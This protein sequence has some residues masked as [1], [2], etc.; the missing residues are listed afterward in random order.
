MGNR[1]LKYLSAAA[2]AGLTWTLTGCSVIGYVMG[3]AIDGPR[4]STE[5]LAVRSAPQS[6]SGI[7]RFLPQ[8]DAD[9][10]VQILNWAAPG[11]GSIVFI[12]TRT[13]A[14]IGGSLMYDEVLALGSDSIGS[15]KERLL[16]GEPVVLALR[17][18]PS[19]QISGR[20]TRIV[21]EG[22]TLHVGSVDR[23]YKFHGLDK[24][25]LSDGSVLRARDL[26]SLSLPGRLIHVRG[27]VLGIGAVSWFIPAQ[28]VTALRIKRSLGWG[29]GRA[30]FVVVGAA[31]DLFSIAVAISFAQ[32]SSGS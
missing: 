9:S 11:K 3:G 30:L 27:F 23:S 18:H 14:F 17:E 10:V 19:I 20:I 28:D 16:P 1:P 2:L 25:A 26:D 31:L 8:F 22:V 4:I 7:G 24:I 12:S 6:D 29:A 32:L 21:Y 15:G 5:T 13:D